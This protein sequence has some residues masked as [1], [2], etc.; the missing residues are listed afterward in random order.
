MKKEKNIK[1]KAGGRFSAAPWLDHRRLNISLKNKNAITALT[2]EPSAVLSAQPD[3]GEPPT[4]R[5]QPSTRQQRLK[6]CPSSKQL[7]QSQYSI[8]KNKTD[9]SM[10]RRASSRR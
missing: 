9:K 8:P 5:E 7:D 4:A 1:R 10:K 3:S 6:S 2:S